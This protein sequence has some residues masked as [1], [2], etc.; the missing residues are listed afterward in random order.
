MNSA[1]TV[2]V[3]PDVDVDFENLERWCNEWGGEFGADVS[4]VAARDGAAVASAL[5]DASAAVAAP[6]SAA[7][8]DAVR[9]AASDTDVVW[10]DLY[11]AEHAAPPYFSRGDEPV[12]RGRG[13][14]GFRW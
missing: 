9:S 10:L 11:E 3:G 2:V 1:V 4:V 6:G 14:F 5:R 13:V 7:A 12:I 8:D